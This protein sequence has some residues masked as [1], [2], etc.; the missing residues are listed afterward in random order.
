MDESYQS[1]D[2]L[3][4]LKKRVKRCV[5]KSCGSRLGLRKID[6]GDFEGAR[7]ELFCNQCDRMEFGIEPE[8][9][10]SAV[11]FVDEFRVNY[12]PDFSD[13]SMVKKLNVS[14]IGNIISWAMLNLGYLEKDGFIAP[15]Q[16][17]Q[18]MLKRCLVL[19]DD[20]MMT[21]LKELMPS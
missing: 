19:D 1:E 12:F 13:V 16:M 17:N 9:Y 4:M 15:P 5:C 20:S 6:F 7:V 14:A 18:Q 8:I 21:L 2:R 3:A 11:Y 10:Q